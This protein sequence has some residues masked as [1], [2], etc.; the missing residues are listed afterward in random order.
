MWQHL[1]APALPGPGPAAGAEQREGEA[2][3]AEEEEEGSKHTNS[4]VLIS[5]PAAPA[6]SLSSESQCH[7]PWWG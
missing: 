2:G 1:L 6:L 5:G 7:I 3:D 4:L